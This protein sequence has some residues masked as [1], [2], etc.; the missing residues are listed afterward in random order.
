MWAYYRVRLRFPLKGLKYLEFNIEGATGMTRQRDR[1]ILDAPGRVGRRIRNASIGKQRW[2]RKITTDRVRSAAPH[3]PVND[4]N[5]QAYYYL[6][7]Y[8]V[9]VVGNKV[10]PITVLRGVRFLAPISTTPIRAWAA[11]MEVPT[12]LA[13]FASNGGVPAQMMV[14]GRRS[15]MEKARM[16]ARKRIR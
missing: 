5:R 10:P 2:H 13:L 4:R 12:L 9:I 1:A 6:C 7:R 11:R 14:W 15:S 3:P 8:F 16:S